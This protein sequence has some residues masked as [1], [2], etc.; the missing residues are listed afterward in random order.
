MA[1]VP[2]V[3]GVVLIP[4]PSLGLSILHFPPP[5]ALASAQ[6]KAIIYGMFQLFGAR[7]IVVGATSLYIWYFGGAREG[8]QEGCR[9]MGWTM[10]GMVL[11]VVVDGL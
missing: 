7:E 5:S 2:L 1:L 9:T 6:D 8:K 3:V 11:L 10:F 4:R